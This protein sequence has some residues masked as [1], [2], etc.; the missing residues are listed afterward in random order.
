M[1]ST[2]VT[3]RK[4]RAHTSTG[5]PANTLSAAASS[6]STSSHTAFHPAR[7]S[8]PCVRTGSG[9][10]TAK[11]VSWPFTTVHNRPARPS[12]KIKQLADFIRME[13]LKQRL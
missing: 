13:N 12:A 4:Y 11:A 8:M 2:L 7:R 5:V 6:G 1:K 3:G 10:S 9:A